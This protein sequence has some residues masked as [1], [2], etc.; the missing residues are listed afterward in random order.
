MARL[1]FVNGLVLLQVNSGRFEI[2]LGHS[3]SENGED[4]ALLDGVVELEILIVS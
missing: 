1:T 2:E 3:L 4:V